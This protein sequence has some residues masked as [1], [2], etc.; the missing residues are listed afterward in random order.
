MERPGREIR[1]EIILT[2]MPAAVVAV[3]EKREVMPA[4]QMA[5]TEE[6][7]FS[8]TSPVWPLGTAAVEPAGLGT[9]PVVPV[10]RVAAGTQEV[11][12]HVQDRTGQP[13]PEVVAEETD[14]PTARLQVRADRVL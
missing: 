13:T 11:I 10:E 4:V 1:E 7:E 6:K 8:P 12:P 3:R 5:E 14:M 9:E 2:T